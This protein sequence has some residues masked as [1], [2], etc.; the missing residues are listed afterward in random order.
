MPLLPPPSPHAA[1]TVVP[2]VTP[3]L[4]L[5]QAAPPIVP[6]AVLLTIRKPRLISMVVRLTWPL[7]L[8][9]RLLFGLLIRLCP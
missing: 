8:K 5:P 6:P 4:P 7:L 3:M 1:M 2:P 9:H